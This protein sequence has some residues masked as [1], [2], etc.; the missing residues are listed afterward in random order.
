VSTATRIFLTVLSLIAV[1]TA[2]AQAQLNYVTV[3]GQLIALPM[4]DGFVDPR[5]GR[6][7][8]A[9][10]IAAVTPV[11]NRNLIYLV[12]PED[13]SRLESQ[14]RVLK[15]EIAKQYEDKD[16]PPPAFEAFREDL[17]KSQPP[18]MEQVA[19]FDETRY[20]ISRLTVGAGRATAA[21]LVYIR[22]KVLYVLTSAAARDQEAVL[23]T[24]ATSHAYVRLFL[25]AN[26]QP[27]KD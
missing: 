8:A 14:A 27:V 20:S 2:H 25:E 24:Q 23:W 9:R 19:I 21:S 6:A 12:P 13:V 7:E 17:R 22:G 18:N 11:D 26:Q 15:V 3:G 5:S 10:I 4:P 16:F 1:A